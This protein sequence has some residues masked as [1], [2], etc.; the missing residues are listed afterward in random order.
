MFNGAESPASRRIPSE[1][2]QSVCADAALS[3]VF[4]FDLRNGIRRVDLSVEPERGGRIRPMADYYSYVSR[5]ADRNDEMLDLLIRW[6]EINSGTGNLAGLD[7]M[8]S[9]LRREFGRLRGETSIIDLPPRK[10]IDSGGNVV[11]TPL[12]KALSVKKRPEAPIKVFLCIHMDTVYPEEH[13]FQ[14]C[15]RLDEERLKGPG[16]ADAK[17]GILVMLHALDALE[18]SPWAERLGWEALITPDEEIGSPGSAPLLA[19]AGRRCHAGLVFEPAL[20]DGNLVGARK[21][22]GNF[23]A[24]V[25]GRAAHAGRDPSAGRNAIDAL[26]RFIVELKDLHSQDPG[27]L[28]NTGWIKGGGAV[29]V[30]PDLALCRFNVRIAGREEQRIVETN[31]HA[32]V[33]E[34]REA[35]GL[36]LEL[37]GDFARPPKPLDEKAGKLFRLVE[38][39]GRDLGISLESRPSGGACDGNNLAAAGLPVVDSLGV[40]GDNLHSD[41]EVLFIDSL[42]E[43]SR[44]TALVL[45]RLAAG[46]TRFG[47]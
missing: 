47:R 24:V 2:P 20:P 22:S 27:I 40:R 37:H 25:R 9:E 28:V 17:G 5:L 35:D 43:R 7:R 39:C 10:R 34:F 8:L 3:P 44:L 21:G 32:L 29:N 14:T 16:T 4:I 33:H 36:S 45:M 18:R 42:R 23:T 41:E 1:C 11:E 19:D 12:G 38:D 30:V 15:T 26:A 13:P 46:E 31:L 6:A